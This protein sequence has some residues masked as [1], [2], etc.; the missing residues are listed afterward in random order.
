MSA[1]TPE[2]LEEYA[3]SLLVFLRNSE[4]QAAAVSGINIG[5]IAYTLQM[6]R[7]AMD[8][9]VAM[10]VGS[11][12]ELVAKLDA[13]RSGEEGIEEFYVGEI[14]REKDSLAVFAGDEE[15]QDAVAKWVER[16]KYGKL[17]GLW[18]KGLSFD[19]NKLYGDE[20]MV[21][22]RRISLPT[23]PFA[24]ERYWIAPVVAAADVAAGNVSRGGLTLLGPGA[25]ESG[26]SEC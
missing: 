23:Y 3:G 15:L 18:V 9:R 11:I 22:A 21:R 25:A 16:G 12:A 24:K 8:A 4:R 2:R 10:M 20:R 5:D 6:G 26:G 7:E 19:W 17:L 13:W 14:K 1:R